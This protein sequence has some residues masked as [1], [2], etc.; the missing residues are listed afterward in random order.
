M[1]AHTHI[2]QSNSF[3]ILRWIK[4]Y[5]KQQRLF[6]PPAVPGEKL[7]PEIL[8][9][10]EKEHHEHVASEYDAAEET[11]VDAEQ[12]SEIKL[13]LPL[14]STVDDVHQNGAPEGKSFQLST[15][16]LVPVPELTVIESVTCLSSSQGTAGHSQVDMAGLDLPPVAAA[17]AHYM[18]IDLSHEGVLAELRKGIAFVIHGPPSSGRT[19]QAQVLAKRYNAAI[20]NLDE[21]LKD[22]I[23]HASTPAGY[24]A[25]EICIEAERIKQ[26]QQEPSTTVATGGRRYTKDKESR[27]KEHVNMV[28]PDDIITLPAE[29]FFVQPLEG[30]LAVPESSLTTSVLPEDL[31]VE[32]LTDR[33]LQSDCRQGIVFDGIE[34]QFMPNPS[35]VLK[36]ILKAINNRKHIYV[37][38]IEVELVALHIRKMQLERE[39]KDR[40]KK[41]KQMKEELNRKEE[42]NI[43]EKLEID[44]DDYESLPEQKKKEID[45]KLLEIKKAKR[46]KKQREKEERERLQREKEEEERRLAEEAAKRKKGKGKKLP[47]TAAVSS[48]S[49]QAP[50]LMQTSIV[51]AVGISSQASVGSGVGTPIKTSKNRRLSDKMTTL[52]QVENVPDTIL[53]KRYDYYQHHIDGVQN[54]L[55][56]WDREAGEVYQYPEEQHVF[57][58]I[59]PIKKTIKSSSM[60]L[61]VHSPGQPPPP[62]VTPPILALDKENV[63][64]PV[65]KVCGTQTISELSEEIFKDLPDPEEV[66][67]SPSAVYPNYVIMYNF[68]E[69]ILKSLGLGANGPPIAAPVVLQVC[70]YPHR[71]SEI[72]VQDQFTF[73]AASPDDMY[74]ELLQCKA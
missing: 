17:I 25:R 14:T 64:V 34:S 47:T 69:Q 39:V 31:I 18:G 72:Q 12:G 23:S 48:P 58:T 52:A 11:S 35:A 66:L 63:G 4:G 32:I 26:A 60:S 50:G 38:N 73:I 40:A 20:I 59:T 44:E 70:L 54:I 62:P 57:A 30:A 42:K 67:I 61:K 71:R 22:L 5:D 65:L 15:T 51:D 56:S 27:D 24:K 16:A 49:Q 53:S 1:H 19:T 55:N 46:L 10:W 2:L 74:V 9:A 7:P 29:T 45:D 43:K 8:Q 41:E 36:A 13:K 21:L 37:V 28:V 33:I 68:N 6:L 3:Q